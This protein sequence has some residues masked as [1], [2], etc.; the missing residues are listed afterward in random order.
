[1]VK[2]TLKEKQL[3]GGG[4]TVLTLKKQEIMSKK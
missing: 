1:M 2:H 3:S 4:T